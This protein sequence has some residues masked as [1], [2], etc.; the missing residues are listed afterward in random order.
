MAKNPMYIPTFIS[1]VNYNAARVLP[2][3]YFYNG[4]KQTDDYYI[5]GY[6]N[7][8]TSS[9]SSRELSVFPYFDN[10]EGNTPNTGSRSLL[11]YNEPSVYGD[12]PTGSLYTNYWA[13]YINLLYNPRTRLFNCEAIIPLA[14]YFKMELNDIV[15]WRGNY[16]HL[17]AINDYNLKNGEC[18]LQLLGPILDD[19]L[20]NILPRIKC[21]FGFG[22]G[23]GSATTTTTSTTTTTAAPCAGCREYTMLATGS[24]ADVT[25]Y[26]LDCTGTPQSVVLGNDDT[27][28]VCSITSGSYPY[29]SASVG[30]GVL[31]SCGPICSSSCECS[32]MNGAVGPYSYYT[33][34]DKTIPLYGYTVVP[35]VY[36]CV[37]SLLPTIG[38][39]L[40]GSDSSGCPGCPTTTT[41]TTT[42]STTTT[43]TTTQPPTTTTTTIQCNTTWTASNYDCGG[44]VLY[45]IGI[46][47]NFMGSLSGPSTFPLTSTLYGYKTNPNGVKCG[48]NNTIQANVT[49]NLPGTGNSGYLRVVVN[50][51]EPT[52][53]QVCF[54]GNPYPQVTGVP[55]NDGDQIWVYVQCYSSS[56]C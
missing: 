39:T 51:V 43:T 42:T 8:N 40:S 45:D 50:G 23:T 11:F 41:T 34:D 30:T 44:G 25:F 36:T 49:T 1:S 16:Y 5:Q 17:R 31:S 18:K 54:T 21:N 19:I 32:D 6:V 9:V 46:N 2:H 20:P 12:T 26:W 27:L 33:C 14:D 22:V 38:L 13:S 47:G 24:G 35:T 28:K 7:Y 37:D 56:T 53:Y 55:I 10:Y 29:Y 48:Q 52:P 15:E 3:I 4:V